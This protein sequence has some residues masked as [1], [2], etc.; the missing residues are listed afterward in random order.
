MR[1]ITTVRLALAA[2]GACL[3]LG[4]CADKA[5]E[6]RQEDLE[7][8]IIRYEAARWAGPDRLLPR[9]FADPSQPAD[10][11]ARAAL[12]MGRIGE[13]EFVPV[14]LAGLGEPAAELRA[15]S[16]FALG[17]IVEA[18]NASLHSFQPSETAIGPTRRRLLEDPSAL[19]R[20]RAVEA[21]GKTGERRWLEDL[22][23]LAPNPDQL[24]GEPTRQL[25]AE[26]W[27]KAALR[28]RHPGCGPG[29]V[30][31]LGT[32]ARVTAA[33]ALARLLG[34]KA[35]RADVPPGVLAEM[36]RNVDPEVRAAAVRLGSVLEPAAPDS[37]ILP[38]L[39]DP[40]PGV[41]VNVLQA[42]GRSRSEAAVRALV[43][44]VDRGL[45]AART[46]DSAALLQKELPVA[47][48]ALGPADSLYAREALARWL[49]GSALLAPHCLQAQVA[50]R[51]D[52]PLP[53]LADV[54]PLRTRARVMRW[55][56]AV[57]ASKHPDAAAFLRGLESGPP[58]AGWH[59]EWVKAARPYY[60][61]A[62]LGA[63]APGAGPGLAGLLADA[64]PY[65]RAA[66]L[67]W[68][69]QQP[70]PP[71]AAVLDEVCAATERFPKPDAP[72]PLVSAIP[73]LAKAGPRGAALLERLRGSDFFQ[74]RLMA[75]RALHAA[76]V[77]DAYRGVAPMPVSDLSMYRNIVQRWQ[78]PCLV[79]MET[80]RGPVALALFR[81]DAPL[82]C[83]NFLKL[84]GERYFDGIAF[85]RVVPD[86]V[87]QGG[88]PLG[89]GN[90]GPGYAIPCEVNELDYTRGRVGM[91]LSGKDSGGSQFFF[92]L[93]R[94]PHLDGGYT[95]FAEVAG[96][97]D[98]VD[99]LTEEDVIQSI[100]VFWDIPW[101][102]R[103]VHRY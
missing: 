38:M 9:L 79:Q 22:P 3:W 4:A 89:S 70:A 74:V 96:G 63:A 71:A 13:P 23:R 97:M 60:I 72:D 56:Q 64:D 1:A 93:S 45:P 15:G 43:A 27:S 51:P 18:E 37:E 8:R 101:E 91:A 11:R 33:K 75:A 44:Y 76:G 62:L 28:T 19:V 36:R 77:P 40:D 90:G 57:A 78:Y 16:L 61:P 102:E 12:A 50:A 85:H 41:R 95:I 32:P 98:V 68:L 49:K 25:Y 26:E 34:Q 81:R 10:V 92:T 35:L 5:A 83:A 86:F 69:Q 21:L 39:Q 17:E 99:R 48:A 30:A 100:R 87:A 6:R 54:P 47:V 94:Q 20:A 24:T 31:L 53:A 67:D 59:P 88:C 66:A 80:S 14:L 65:V 2:A 82:T 73:L 7:A 58:P 84:A 103:D 55:I 29:L 46:G 52:A 42:L